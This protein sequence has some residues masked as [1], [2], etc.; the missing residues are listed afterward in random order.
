[1]AVEKSLFDSWFT[2]SDR[3]R[4]TRRKRLLKRRSRTV[5]PR[6]AG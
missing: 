4:L 6:E 5:N 3:Q 1:M 2:S